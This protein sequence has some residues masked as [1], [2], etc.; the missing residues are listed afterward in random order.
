MTKPNKKSSRV[1]GWLR[2]AASGLGEGSGWS[3]D[4]PP[5][6]PAQRGPSAQYLSPAPSTRQPLPTALAPTRLSNSRVVPYPRGTA[7]L[8]SRPL[9]STWVMGVF[10]LLCGATL[11]WPVTV[12]VLQ[13]PLQ[14]PHHGPQGLA[15]SLFPPPSSHFNCTGLLSF[16]PDC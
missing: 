8:P 1:A 9:V 2:Q 3:R 12:C 15:S 11:P 4:C 5:A 14:I 7:C 16:P 13:L 6:Q 10:Q